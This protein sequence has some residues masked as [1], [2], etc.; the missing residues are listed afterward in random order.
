MTE[1]IKKYVLLGVL[2]SC[3]GLVL[4][5]MPESPVVN[6]DMSASLQLSSQLN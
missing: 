2:M 4:Y 5:A 6:E 1:S 3:L